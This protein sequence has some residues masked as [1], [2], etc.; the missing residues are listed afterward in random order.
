MQN[1]YRC[2]QHAVTAQ[3]QVNDHL[4]IFAQV[5]SEIEV[6]TFLT[7]LAIM[8]GS[9]ALGTPGKGDPNGSVTTPA[10]FTSNHKRIKHNHE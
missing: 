6:C 9:L 1:M 8:S 10:Q 4:R 5:Q 2:V 3:H 7:F